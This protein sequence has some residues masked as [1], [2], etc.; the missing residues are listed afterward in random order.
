[1]KLIIT[2]EQERLLIGTLLNEQQ[3]YTVEPEKVL[4]VKKY[5]DKNYV[6]GNYSEV[7]GGGDIK[8]TPIAGRKNPSTGNIE[9][10]VYKGQMFDQLESHFKNIYDNKVKRTKFLK[11]V[12]HDWF[13]GKITKEGLLSVNRF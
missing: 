2:E 3:T 9:T 6:K 10:N 13:N 11:Q 5:L 1:M 12:I 4:V 8:N 7:T